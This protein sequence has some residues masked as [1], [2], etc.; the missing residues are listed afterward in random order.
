MEYSEL[1]NEVQRLSEEVKKLAARVI[2]LEQGGG[3]W[4]GCDASI[5]GTADEVLDKILG[6]DVNH[7]PR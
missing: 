5:A 4:S 1:E 3:G 7:P 6:D 2:V